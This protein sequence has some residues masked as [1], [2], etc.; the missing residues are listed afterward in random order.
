MLRRIEEAGGSVFIRPERVT[1][2]AWSNEETGEVVIIMQDELE[3]WVVLGTPDSVH[4]ALFPEPAT[5]AK[6]MGLNANGYDIPLRTEEKDVADALDPRT[7]EAELQDRSPEHARVFAWAL[8]LV[9]A[10]LGV[11]VKP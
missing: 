3:P 8:S 7:Y 2:I 5:P 1:G 4:A 11:E 6:L 9:R 10:R